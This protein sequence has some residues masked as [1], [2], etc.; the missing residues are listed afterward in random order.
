MGLVVG[1]GRSARLIV[2]RD[3][4][5]MTASGHSCRFDRTTATSALPPVNGHSQNK[6]AVS[7]VREAAGTSYAALFVAGWC[8]GHH[9]NN[10]RKKWP[11][12]CP[13][14]TFL[15]GGGAVAR[16][17]LCA[18]LVVAL[19]APC[20]VPVV[21]PLARFAVPDAAPCRT[22]RYPRAVS[23]AWRVWW[24][25]GL[26]PAIPSELQTKR[27]IQMPPRVQIKRERW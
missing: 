1:P 25:F 12:I 8:S 13:S 18:A 5:D 11:P 9:A 10:A 2:A 16:R 19:R 15:P 24:W 3:K 23:L 6:R 27:Q 20:V 4:L 21:V 26:Q 14:I 22:S 17:V 7:K